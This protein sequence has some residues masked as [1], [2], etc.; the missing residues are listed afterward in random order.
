MATHPVGTGS[1]AAPARTGQNR[2]GHLLAQIGDR[3]AEAEIHLTA[4]R[5]L[6]EAP[7]QKDLLDR[8]FAQINGIDA[9]LYRLRHALQSS[10]GVYSGPGCYRV[11]FLNEVARA[12]KTFTVCQRSIVVP[13]ARSRDEAI[14]AAKQQFAELECIPDWHLHAA[15]IE[16]DLTAIEKER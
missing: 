16:A 11:C 7:R 13:D 8:A 12:D 6:T 15:K 5:N 2:T 10:P 14:T 1:P 4:L 3:L 9:L